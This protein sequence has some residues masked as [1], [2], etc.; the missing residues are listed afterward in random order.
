MKI[1]FES[2]E[3]RTFFMSSCMNRSRCEKCVF[4]EFCEK[5]STAFEYLVNYYYY[6]STST[7]TS[8]STGTSNVVYTYLGDDY[9]SGYSNQISINN[10]SA[11]HKTCKNIIAPDELKSTFIRKDGIYVFKDR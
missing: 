10:T 9:D 5:S 1:F 3:E 11:A 2:R 8:T 4:S 7:S 6:P